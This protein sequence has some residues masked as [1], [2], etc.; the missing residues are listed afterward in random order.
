M[1]IIAKNLKGGGGNSLKFRVKS[2]EVR[3]G[4]SSS[5]WRLGKRELG[6]GKR[7]FSLFNLHCSLSVLLAGLF[8]LAA[9]GAW[10][11]AYWT[12][13]GSD[14]LFT[15]AGNWASSPTYNI[16][17]DHTEKEVSSPF[18]RLNEDYTSKFKVP[19]D[20]NNCCRGL[21]F[22]QL[23]EDYTEWFLCGWYD[24]RIH[25][26]YQTEE[27]NNGILNV[28]DKKSTKARLSAIDIRV[29]SV[30]VGGEGEGELILDEYDF[31]GKTQRGPVSLESQGDFYLKKGS[32]TVRSGSVTVNKEKWTRLGESGES[33]LNL[34]GGTFATKHIH[35]YNNSAIVNFNGGTLKANNTYTKN[36]GLIMSGVT[37]NVGDYGG[38]IDSGNN[39]IEIAA[40]LG[41]TGVM[42]FKGGNTITL[43]SEN[44]YK[45]ETKIAVRT[46]LVVTSTELARLLKNG[47]I[48]VVMPEGV[49]AKGTFKLLGKSDGVCRAEEYERITKDVGLE[50]AV[51]AIDE[52]GDI[53][54][55][56]SHTPQTWAGA[57]EVSA[58][59]GGNNWDAGVAFD[60]GND[61]VFATDGAIAEVD[62]D[63]SAYTLTFNDNAALTGTGT[64]T[65]PTITVAEDK[66]A[67]IAGPLAGPI[68]KIGTGTL[69]L[70]SSRTGMTT[71][72]SEGTLVANAPVGTLVLGTDTAKPVTFDYG[73]QTYSST[74]YITDGL[75]V[76]LTNSTFSSFYRVANGTVHV[77]KN[78]MVYRSGWIT[79]GPESE[80]D[81]TAAMLDICGG[82]VSNATKNIGIGDYGLL[83]SSAEVRVRNGGLLATSNGIL[84]GSRAAATLTIDEGTVV[85]QYDI[86]FC[87]SSSEVVSGEDSFLNLN[88]GGLLWV[89]SI[90]FGKGAANATFTFN[91]GT[92]KANQDR[93][94][95]IENEPLLSIVTATS[96]TIDAD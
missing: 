14:D 64:L 67:S 29:C 44:T 12:G 66:T 17:F 13:A 4:G 31:D 81:N 9:S 77:A 82:V 86:L 96:G 24:G 41:G 88:A 7:N 70:G 80:L 25:K 89:R 71:T 46:K 73:G 26:Y 83:G 92:L 16:V 68:E 1:N 65:V 39:A 85:A 94:P 47:G 43:T 95:F 63:Y 32:M 11:A 19:G 42:T 22:R 76:T 62:A 30:T 38:M 93:S 51:F 2:E 50:G 90:T 21:I 36:G 56:V 61:A 60:D 54:V 28:G 15:T 48:K 59:W 74:I 8:A 58:T 69:T 23:P 72:L 18:A 75:E 87:D 79:V 84:V 40:A 5:S 55:T 6:R 45:G 52:D 3:V 91:G 20:K 35:K 27:S 10:A 49:S 37:V 78:A 53:T 57:S 34:N 33:I